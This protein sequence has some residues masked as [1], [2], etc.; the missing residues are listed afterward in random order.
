MLKN[1]TDK[2]TI[3][4]KKA[5]VACGS[6]DDIDEKY[7]KFTNKVGAILYQSKIDVVYGGGKT[8]LMG[9]LSN[10]IKSNGGNVIG[11]IPKNFFK[12]ENMNIGNDVIYVNNMY[13]RK[14]VMFG[15]SDIFIALPG[16]L[17]TMD[18]IFEVITLKLLGHYSKPILILNYNGFY[19]NFFKLIDFLIKQGFAKEKI[20]KQYKVLSSLRSLS[21]YL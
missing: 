10:T 21:K 4:H 5:F 11:V 13:E 16:G 7:K 8:G 3:M 9:A 14:R 2:K 15:I 17:G 6:S 18:E 20:V 1:G 19:K 12:K